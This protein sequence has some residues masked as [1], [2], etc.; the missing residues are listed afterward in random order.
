[1]LGHMLTRRGTRGDERVGLGRFPPTGI[2]APSRTVHPARDSLSLLHASPD[3]G[4]Y[5]VFDS[6]FVVRVLA[7]PPH[8]GISINGWTRLI[9]PADPIAQGAVC[10][11]DLNLK[12]AGAPATRGPESH[13]EARNIRCWHVD[14]DPRTVVAHAATLRV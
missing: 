14:G 12:P 7:E 9:L 4:C 1:M 8:E 11:A 5:H 10:S 2:P 6:L 3:K 13:D